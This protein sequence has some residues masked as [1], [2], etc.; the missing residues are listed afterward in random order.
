MSQILLENDNQKK[1][2]IENNKNIEISNRVTLDQQK[3]FLDSNLGKA[4]NSG[5]NIGLRLALP[6]LIEDQVIEIKDVLMNQGL[7]EGIKT[8][9]NSVMDFA[10]SVSGIFTGKFENISQLENAVKNGGIIDNTSKALGSAIEL[11]QKNKLIDASTATLLKKGKNAILNS[12]NNNIESM[13]T[14]QI[15]SIEKIEKYISKW[16]NAYANN[17]IEQ[18]KKE[19]KQINTELNKVLPLENTIKEARK[20][21]NIHNLIINNGYNF[22]LSTI[23]VELAKKLV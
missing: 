15:K 16:E 21:E 10:K 7:K 3:K 6:D 20:I 9:S 2:Q 13:L 23:E 8:I 17:D 11:A 14:D 1:L 12:V 4:I 22:E 18:M 5:V 19:F